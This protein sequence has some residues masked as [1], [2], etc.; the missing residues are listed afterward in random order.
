MTYTRSQ[1]V[2]R[3]NAS[4]TYATR[5]CMQWTRTMAGINAIGDFD[6][7]K[8]ADAEDGWKATPSKHPGDRKPPA[9]T[10]VWYGGG[11]QD[12]GHAAVSLGPNERGIYMIRTT[13]GK[14]G[15]PGVNGTQPLDYPE[16]NWGMPYLGWTDG[17]GNDVPKNDLI[18]E[19]NGRFVQLEVGFWN[20]KVDASLNEILKHIEKII[21]E[22]DP[23]LLLLAEAKHLRGHLNGLG[24]EIFQLKAT[25]ADANIAVMVRDGLNVKRNF[26]LR[27][28]ERWIGPRAGVNQDPRVYRTIKVEKGGIVWKVGGFH[29]PFGTAARRESVKAVRKWF[30]V[31]TKKRPVIAVGDWQRGEGPIKANVAD[32][33]GARISGD[34]L[35]LAIFKNC[36]LV[37]EKNLGKGVSDHP[38]M[39]WVFRKW[40]KVSR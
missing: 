22:E 3:A 38:A 29:F 25:S 16:K 39:L 14:P 11:S 40:K 6:G 4:L 33:V 7:D 18:T 20:V 34:G 27:M 28:K 36:G 8:A 35:D 23:D 1:I 31:T 5:M 24:Y 17:I 9:G 21:G 19:K 30:R 32:L 2:A 26:V 10:F 12:N 15:F 13:D 37:K